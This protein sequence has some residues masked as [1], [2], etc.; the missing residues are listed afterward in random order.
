ML[1]CQWP[2]K[3]TIKWIKFIAIWHRLCMDPFYLKVTLSFGSLKD[4]VGRSCSIFTRNAWVY[5]RKRNCRSCN[6]LIRLL[7]DGTIWS[8]WEKVC[9]Y[10]RCGCST[11]RR[12]RRWQ[13]VCRVFKIWPSGLGLI[14]CCPVCSTWLSLLISSQLTLQKKI[15]P[16]YTYCVLR[17]LLL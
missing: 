8:K 14:Y 6:W 3:E 15:A 11:S 1:C 10:T 4:A 9:I 13:S 17:C 12:R 5:M 16:T 7:R 2:H